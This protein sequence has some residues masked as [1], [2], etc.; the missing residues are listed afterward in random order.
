MNKVILVI[1]ATLAGY[2]FISVKWHKDVRMSHEVQTAEFASFAPVKKPASIQMQ[3]PKPKPQKEKV[4]SFLEQKTGQTWSLEKNGTQ[5]VSLYGGLVKDVDTDEKL[6]SF[7]T[8]LAE[9]MG[10]EKIKFAEA[11]DLQKQ[12]PVESINE[13]HQKI[14]NFEIYGAY[15]RSFR[16]SDELNGSFFINEF[17][18]YTEVI[19]AESFSLEDAQQKI[20][21]YYGRLGKTV[22]STDCANKVYY[23]NK[24]QTAELSVKC[25]VKTS[26]QLPETFEV[27]VSLNSADILFQKPI[28][29][30]N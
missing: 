20:K 26:S 3:N 14:D 30:F 10:Y 19:S 12:T 27:V 7:V 11:K 9:S 17:K 6:N 24:N 8:E 15:F 4:I 23:I 2:Y 16:D 25:R 29:I 22:L 18:K 21:D 5:I 1:A 13:F 28:T